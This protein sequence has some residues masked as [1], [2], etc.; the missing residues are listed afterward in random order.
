[1]SWWAQGKFATEAVAVVWLDV[2]SSFPVYFVSRFQ[3]FCCSLGMKDSL[4]HCSVENW[5]K[6]HR[7]E[8]VCLSKA[9]DSLFPATKSH[10]VQKNTL[11]NRLC[12]HSPVKQ[13]TLALKINLTPSHLDQPEWCRCYA[14]PTRQCYD[15]PMQLRSFPP[16]SKRPHTLRWPNMSPG[17]HGLSH[18]SSVFLVA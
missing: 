1:M 18:L 6:I 16:W 9:T 12:L 11:P 15:L 3:G 17:R 10:L 13:P 5:R 2:D 14:S 4:P 7:L 8:S